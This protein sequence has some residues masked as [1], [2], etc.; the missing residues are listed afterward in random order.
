MTRRRWR[1]RR[2]QGSG[3]Q[4]A[5]RVQSSGALNGHEEVELQEEAERKQVEKFEWPAGGGDFSDLSFPVARRDRRECR[6]RSFGRWEMLREGRFK[7]PG[8]LG[9]AERMQV[10]RL[11]ALGEAERMQT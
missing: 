3:G 4:E 5:E 7:C 2:F 9:E 11:R 6:F 1:E 8:R 10:N